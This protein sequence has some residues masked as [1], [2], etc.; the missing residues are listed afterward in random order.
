M[1]SSPAT[2]VHPEH[3]VCP[4]AN[5][6]GIQPQTD[7]KTSDGVTQKFQGLVQGHREP[8]EQDSGL[9]QLGA[10]VLCSSLTAHNCSCGESNLT[11]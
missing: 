8:E 7:T 11:T 5:T 4:M 1:G 3:L 10:T 9:S 2:P 6:Q